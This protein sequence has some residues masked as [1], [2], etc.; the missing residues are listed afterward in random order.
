MLAHRSIRAVSLRHAAG[1]TVGPTLVLDQGT[2]KQ[3]KLSGRC[4]TAVEVVAPII[5]FFF[6]FFFQVAPNENPTLQLL[7]GTMYVPVSS[8]ARALSLRHAACGGVRPILL[9]LLRGRRRRIISAVDV[10]QQ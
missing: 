4:H 2:E 5:T 1:G 10:V 7:V 8:N 6:V 3:E 9:I